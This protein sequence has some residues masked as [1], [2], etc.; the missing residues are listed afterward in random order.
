M[1]YQ[2]GKARFA[3]YIAPIVNEA[4][5][6]SNGVLV[7]PFCGGCNLT[8]HF[9]GKIIAND[10]NK[11]LIAL[12][13]EAVS[14]RKFPDSVS[15]EMYEEAKNGNLDD[16]LTAYI[17]FCAS[18]RGKYLS[19][20]IGN[21]RLTTGGRIINDQRVAINSFLRTVDGLRSLEDLEFSSLPYYDLEIKEGS[22][23]YCDPPYFGALGYRTGQFDH[24]H[25]WKW[26][27]AVS[28]HSTVFVSE[29]TTLSDFFM[30]VWELN[31][32]VPLSPKEKRA[33]EKLFINILN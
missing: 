10:L 18:Y 28:E 31:A 14:G 22:V 33:T 32:R 1:H 13:K 21:N 12:F 7:E 19:G 6:K 4:V 16:A 3:K 23:V 26:A 25:F 9:K 2:G 15:S 27:E 30:P 5:K 20:Y 17:G 24:E 11:N 29:Y 8:T